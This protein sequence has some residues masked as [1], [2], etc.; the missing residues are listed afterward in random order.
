MRLLCG[1]L[2]A[3]SVGGYIAYNQVVTGAIKDE[4]QA[5]KLKALKAKFDEEFDELDKRFQ[6][7][8]EAEQ[9]G[10]QTELRELATLTAE[11]AR[12]IAEED[13][14]SQEAFETVVYALS[15]LA[16]LGAKGPDMDKLLAIATEH[17][18]GNPKAKDLVL[19][20]GRGGAAGEK[21][22]QAAAE[23]APDKEVKAIAMLILG[24]SY[25]EQSDRATSEK[26]SAEL[27]A[28]AVDYLSRAAKEA[29]DAK[30]G[31]QKLGEIATE[32]MKSIKLLAVGSPVP[33]LLG[34]ELRDQKKQKLSDFKGNV[35]LVDI[36]ATWCGPCREMIPHEREMVKRLANKPFKLIGVSADTEKSKLT[37]FLESNS[38]PWIH[39]WD[40]GKENPLF[41]TLKIEVFPTLYLIDAKGVIRKKMFGYQEPEV[42][43]KAVDDLIK[44]A[45]K[46]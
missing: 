13:P 40:E 29:P 28:K 1:A 45:E 4:N 35:V 26:E 43:D 41:E 17:H 38:M 36:W 7:A 22:L 37:K 33:E 32:L 27:V 19:V 18:L 5:A 9:T 31:R 20:A 11:K 8:T 44:E 6:K 46:K 24:N 39:W 16:K 12:K 34:T 15:Q 3:L 23:K 21:F 42:L 30:L 25:G 14:K 10:I 2:V